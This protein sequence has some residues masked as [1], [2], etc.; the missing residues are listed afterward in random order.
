[1]SPLMTIIFPASISPLT[2]AFI[3]QK[4]LAGLWS[5][6]FRLGLSPD[7]GNLHD[8]TRKATATAA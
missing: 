3:H 8:M 6:R 1:M 4:P 2:R 7:I 5:W